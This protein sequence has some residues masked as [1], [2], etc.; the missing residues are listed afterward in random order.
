M[1]SFKSLL[2]P[3]CVSDATQST[4]MVDE[5]IARCRYQSGRN[6]RRGSALFTAD[7]TRKGRSDRHD[8]VLELQPERRER[9]RSRPID[10]LGAVS[11]I[12]DGGVAGAD[13]RV[14]LLRPHVH[15]AALVR[16]DRRIDN[17]AL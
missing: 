9:T 16:A 15:R 17:D 8:A 1:R 5:C 7:A 10:H 6:V 14:V 3:C 4:M 11:G 12:E 13:E 2:K